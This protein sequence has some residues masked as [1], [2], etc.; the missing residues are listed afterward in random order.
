MPR[1]TKNNYMR[2]RKSVEKEI[3]IQLL[4]NIYYAKMFTMQIWYMP[5]NWILNLFSW[6]LLLMKTLY[7]YNDYKLYVSYT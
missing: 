5:C 1:Q 6:E 7:K 4:V 2:N 3:N